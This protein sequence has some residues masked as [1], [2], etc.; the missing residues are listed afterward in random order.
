MTRLAPWLALLWLAGCD[1][2]KKVDP[3]NPSNPS[4]APATPTPNQEFGCA[5]AIAPTTPTEP[6]QPPAEITAE[7]HGQPTEE[8]AHLAAEKAACAKVGEAADCVRSGKYKLL[9]G[10]VKREK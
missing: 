8:A 3:S 1:S 6:D 7:A 5:I 2:K 4:G 9:R 10:E